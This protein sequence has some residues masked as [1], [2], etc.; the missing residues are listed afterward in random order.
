[1]WKDEE[2]YQPEKCLLPTLRDE[3]RTGPVLG[4]PP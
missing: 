4:G 3:L 1:M 2:E